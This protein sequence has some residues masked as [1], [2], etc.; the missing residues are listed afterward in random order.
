MLVLGLQR[1]YCKQALKNKALHRVH[2][3]TD[4]DLLGSLDRLIKTVTNLI[5]D[6]SLKRCTTCMWHVEQPETVLRH[7]RYHK[8][9]T[10]LTLT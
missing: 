6:C 7:L 8:I 9:H 10:S 4:I 1:F 3:Q 5:D 2:I